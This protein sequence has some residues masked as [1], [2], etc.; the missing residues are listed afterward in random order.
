MH[1]RIIFRRSPSK[2]SEVTD[3]PFAHSQL[4]FNLS[5]TEEAAQVGAKGD[6]D[7]TG[8]QCYFRGHRNYI[9]T[10]RN[11]CNPIVQ[12]LKAMVTVSR[13]RHPISQ[14]APLDGQVVRNVL[15]ARVAQGLAVRASYM[16]AA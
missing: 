12:L 10:V 6:T 1:H 11:V 14:V 13:C 5:S 7:E 15:A 8:L 4:I 2:L 3:L 9:I 16:C